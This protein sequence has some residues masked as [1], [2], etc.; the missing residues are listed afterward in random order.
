MR[1]IRRY[2]KFNKEFF[3]IWS[4]TKVG[5]SGLAA[6]FQHGPLFLSGCGG[7]DRSVSQLREDAYASANDGIMT[8]PPG[9]FAAL[10]LVREDLQ[11]VAPPLALLIFLADG[12][13][14]TP[15]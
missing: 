1:K 4:G 9:L 10:S 14:R 5:Y 8:S 6:T 13:L 2:A 3:F 7:R 15:L 12:Y 11:R